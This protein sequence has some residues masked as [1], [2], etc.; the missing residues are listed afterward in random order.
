MTYY[1]VIKGL[2]VACVVLSGSGFL[3]RGILM[4]NDSP[5]PRQRWLKILPHVNDTVLLAAALTLSVMAGWYPFVDAWITAK[6]FGL[7]AYIIL[8]SLAL[9]PGRS[10]RI[11]LGS[12]LAALATF[13]YIVSVALLRDPRGALGLLGWLV[14]LSP[15][16]G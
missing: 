2:H 10:K 7:V 4:L 13:G 3:L 15:A 6:V 9:Q 16:G 12:W 1:L 8:G 11:R 5:M 14:P